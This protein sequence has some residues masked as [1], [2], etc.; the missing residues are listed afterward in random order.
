[1]SVM[2]AGWGRCGCVQTVQSI[3]S[4]MTHDR[5]GRRGGDLFST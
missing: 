2:G 3:Q 1:M 5:D 4:G